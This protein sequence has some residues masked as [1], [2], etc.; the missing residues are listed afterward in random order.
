MSEKTRK[1][2][3]ILVGDSRVYGFEKFDYIN[4]HFRY[5][6]QRGAVVNNL[7]NDTL[8]IV[9]EYKD[10]DRPVIVKIYCGINEF[11]VFKQR[12][13]QRERKEG[14]RSRETRAHRDLRFNDNVTSR[15]VFD[16]LKSL[17]RKIKTILP[18][19]VVGFVTI[20]TLSV[21]KYRDSKSDKEQRSLLPTDEQLEIDQTKLDNKLNLLNTGLEP[22]IKLNLM[23]I[24][25]HKKQEVKE[26]L[27]D[28]LEREVIRT[29]NSPCSSPIV[30]VKKKDNNILCRFSES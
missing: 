6:I 13:E 25:M 29:S 30:L 15:Q 1:P 23:R 9:S 3:L 10:Q 28:M 7:I 26:L 21:A 16:K 19:A 20:P 27:N 18:T 24:P 22:A 5:V 11:T 17:K 14:K 2:V 4:F 12:K 8:S